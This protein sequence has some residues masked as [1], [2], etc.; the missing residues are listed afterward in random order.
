MLTS[1]HLLHS[2]SRERARTEEIKK[3]PD[4]HYRCVKTNFKSVKN[5]AVI[6]NL[7]DAAL[8]A[9]GIIIHTLQLLKQNLLHCYELGVKL[10]RLDKVFVTSVMKVLCKP[11]SQGRPSHTETKRIKETPMAFYERHYQVYVSEEINYWP[12]M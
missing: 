6:A 7:T 12:M 8:R 11:P 9:N 2:D 4:P 5:D 10:P 1:S 3:P